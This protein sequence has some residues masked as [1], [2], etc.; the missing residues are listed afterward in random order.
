MR[1]LAQQVLFAALFLTSAAILRAADDSR[2]VIDDAK[3]AAPTA[4][5]LDLPRLYVVGDS[6]A[7]S[8]APLRGWGSEIGAFFDP[9]KINVV[10]RAIGGR[11]TRT[12]ITDGRW[13]KILAELKPGDFVLVQFGHNDDG[14]YRDPKAKGRPSIRGDGDETAEAIKADLKTMETIHTFGWY[15]RKYASDATAKG[16]T[17]ILLSKVPHKDWKDGHIVRERDQATFIK[18]TREAATATGA[19]FVDANE[20]ISEGFERL[21]PDKV[22]PLFGDQRT[23]SSPEGARYNAAAIVAGLKALRPNPLAPYFSKA[24]D[25]LPPSL[26]AP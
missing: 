20:I 6:T 5:R 25:D 3:L 9:E 24:A 17:P 10:N 7:R 12:F 26:R 23:H 4:Q 2:P 8:D 19:R 1:T 22:A 18:W 15:L 16:A 13:D 11:S 14:D 21:G